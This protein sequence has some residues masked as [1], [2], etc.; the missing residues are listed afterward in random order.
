MVAF[1]PDLPLGKIQDQ[2]SLAS[3][4][5]KSPKEERYVK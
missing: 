3:E 4:L 5:F 1:I 2:D